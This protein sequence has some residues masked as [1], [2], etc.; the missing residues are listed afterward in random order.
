KAE[1]LRGYHH[2]QSKFLFEFKHKKQQASTLRR[3][4]Y[5]LVAGLEM[6]VRL[7]MFDFARAARVLGRITGAWRYPD[8][9]KSRQTKS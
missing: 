6:L 9:M 4:R 5:C 2:I 7:V 1:Y 3:W 8:D